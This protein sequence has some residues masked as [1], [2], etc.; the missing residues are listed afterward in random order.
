MINTKDDDK[1]R[2]LYGS[3]DVQYLTFAGSVIMGCI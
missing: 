2:V 3:L 1:G